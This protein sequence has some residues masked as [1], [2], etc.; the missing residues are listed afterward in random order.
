[1]LNFSVSYL[2][3]D[4]W[5]ELLSSSYLIFWNFRNF[6][7]PLWM[8]I[9]G[10]QNVVKFTYL[11]S[12]EAVSNKCYAKTVFWKVF[13]KLCKT[14]KDC[15]STNFEWLFT[16]RALEGYLGT[17]RTLQGHFSIWALKALKAP[18]HLSTRALGHLM[19]LI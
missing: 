12:K 17:P 16:R 14:M 15:I 10:L 8:S 9:S 5:R 2:L 1:M 18:R 7:K 4:P 6:L 13:K 19:H 11:L 3:N